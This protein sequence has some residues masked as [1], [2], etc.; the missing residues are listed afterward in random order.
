MVQKLQ[1]VTN[2]KHL[3]IFNV[4]DLDLDP[5]SLTLKLYLDV[6]VTYLHDKNKINRSMGSIVMAWINTDGQTDGQ[7]DRQTDRQTC[8]KSFW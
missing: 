4:C 7:I 6:V 3:V 1:L 8:V 5:M 2:T